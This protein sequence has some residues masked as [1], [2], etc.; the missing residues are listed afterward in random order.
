MGARSKQAAVLLKQNNPELSVFS[1]EGGVQA[2]THNH[3]I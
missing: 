1:L 2:L 3:L